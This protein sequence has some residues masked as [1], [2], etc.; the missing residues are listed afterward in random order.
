MKKS[1]IITLVIIILFGLIVFTFIGIPELKVKNNLEKNI[2]IV[3]GYDTFWSYDFENKW[4]NS[5][6]NI[7]Y[8]DAKYNIYIYS[9]Y[10]GKYDLDLGKEKWYYF[11]SN[12]DDANFKGELFAYNGTRKFKMIDYKTSEI[13]TDDL[14]Y[15]N[16][17]NDSIN[18]SNIK[19]TD[20]IINQK[21]SLDMDNDGKEEQLYAISNFYCETCEN[22][23]EYYSLVFIVDD[24]KVQL[25]AQSYTDASNYSSVP[26]YDINYIIDIDE[27]NE[28]EIILS[29]STYGNNKT[30]HDLFIKSKNKYKKVISSG[31]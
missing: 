18:I 27:D 10:M 17:I 25:L 9:Q 14:K 2:N 20:L 16:E 4:R 30:Y 28:Y 6:S 31:W 23:S 5:G 19:I 26:I 21:V 24:N 13:L 1:Y 8:G 12:Y 3:I 22:I 29:K 7:V 11:D 15:L